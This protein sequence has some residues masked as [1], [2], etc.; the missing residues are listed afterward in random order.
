MA[1][2]N[3]GDLQVLTIY[4]LGIN[5]NSRPGPLSILGLNVA[6]CDAQAQELDIVIPRNHL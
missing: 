4:K 5:L 3:S 6:M 1:R 2:I